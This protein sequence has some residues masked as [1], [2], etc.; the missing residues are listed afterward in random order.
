MKSA[1]YSNG[2]GEG[3]KMAVDFLASTSS[4]MGTAALNNRQE[5]KKISETNIKL[6]HSI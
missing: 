3:S 6:A 2:G 5:Q 4:L 1:R